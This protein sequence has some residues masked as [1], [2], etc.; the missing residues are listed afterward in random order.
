MIVSLTTYPARIESVAITIASIFAQSVLPDRVILVL[1]EEEFSES[2]LPPWVG[3]YVQHGLEVEL[4]PGNTRSYKKLLPTLS[5]YPDRTI[6]TADDDI[7][8]PRRWLEQ[9]VEA[10]RLEPRTIL[11][12]RGTVISSINHT[13]RPYVEWPHARVDSPPARVFLT[14][15][16]GILY[17]SG[18][19]AP[20][21]LDIDL[22][23]Q[24]CPTG[25]DIWFKVC[26]LLASTQS[27]KISN[28]PAEYTVVKSSQETALR[29]SN[30]LST[31][32]DL[33]FA[34]AMNHFDLW[35]SLGD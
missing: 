33:Q 20:V 26:G 16:G 4:V 9:L 8:Y 3:A 22:A 21:V 11:G 30:I 1:S 29:K 27:R 13:A 14:G 6:V 7:I 10:Q 18:S 17:P 34:N 28:R 12:Q 32:N 2:S 23:Q 31:G 15:M 35:H 5:R 19:L 25:D 24:L